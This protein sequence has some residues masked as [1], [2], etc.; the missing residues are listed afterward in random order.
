VQA[1]FADFGEELFVSCPLPS[2]LWHRPSPSEP[3]VRNAKRTLLPPKQTDEEYP[4]A[5]DREQRS[6]GVEFSRKDLEHNQ[7]KRELPDGGAHICAFK[8]PLRCANLDQFRA[9]EHN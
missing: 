5:V 3:R 7:G 4:R 1:I 9:G 2:A 6:D 8:R